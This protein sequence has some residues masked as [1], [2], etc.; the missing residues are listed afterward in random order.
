MSGPPDWARAGAK[1]ICVDA[2]EGDEFNKVDPMPVAGKVYVIADV[3]DHMLLRAPRLLIDGM[4]N[5][6]GTYKADWGWDF[7]RFRPVDQ[8][9]Q[10]QDVAMFTDMLDYMPIIERLDRLAEKMN[11]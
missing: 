11:Q 6:D 7:Y 1:V 2:D 3:F 9:S 4:P 5:R 8:R 10:A